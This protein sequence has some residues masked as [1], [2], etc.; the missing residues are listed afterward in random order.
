MYSRTEYGDNATERVDATTERVD[1]TAERVDVRTGNRCATL[2]FLRPHQTFPKLLYA[3]LTPLTTRAA[4]MQ[5]GLNV[6]LD[7][8]SH[9][10]KF[11]INR[12]LGS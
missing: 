12:P 4:S 5:I 3:T 7:V 8:L 1:A 2:G 6:Q 9:I 10:V 11:E